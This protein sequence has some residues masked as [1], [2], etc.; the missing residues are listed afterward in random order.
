MWRLHFTL[1][2][3]MI[4]DAVLVFE[5]CI[6]DNRSGLQRPEWPVG[7]SFGARAFGIA[8]TTQ[9]RTAQAPNPP[10]R[11]RPRWW[12]RQH[13]TRKLDGRLAAAAKVAASYSGRHFKRTLRRGSS[14]KPC[15][16]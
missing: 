7:R 15:S 3:T 6:G 10:R 12:W 9:G 14:T 1:P 16:T 4:I 5:D 2:V 11:A 8:S 13:F